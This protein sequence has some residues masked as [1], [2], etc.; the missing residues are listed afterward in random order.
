MRWVVVGGRRR[1]LGERKE[2]DSR[3]NE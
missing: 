2:E 3:R 1:G